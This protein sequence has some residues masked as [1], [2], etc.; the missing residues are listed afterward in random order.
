MNP[1]YF[2]DELTPEAQFILLICLLVL[3]LGTVIAPLVAAFSPTATNNL[4]NLVTTIAQLFKSDPRL[5]VR[6][7]RK[8]KSRSFSPTKKSDRSR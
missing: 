4:C 8:F 7:H 6:H 2:L 1:S 5:Q 3:S